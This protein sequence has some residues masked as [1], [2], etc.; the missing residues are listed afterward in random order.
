MTS[1]GTDNIDIQAG[2]KQRCPISALLFNIVIDPIIRQLQGD[3][4][5]QKKLAYAD[6]LVL[7]S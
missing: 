2:I 3:E 6:D 4:P 7:M 1:G 5:E